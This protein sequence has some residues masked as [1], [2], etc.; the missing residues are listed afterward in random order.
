MLTVVS[1]L[2][3]DIVQRKF[4]DAA[5]QPHAEEHWR[6]FV[7]L[8]RFIQAP[9]ASHAAEFGYPLAVQLPGA[10]LKK[11]CGQASADTDTKLREWLQTRCLFCWACAPF[12]TVSLLVTLFVS[13]YVNVRPDQQKRLDGE[14]RSFLRLS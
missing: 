13:L 10:M 14:A 6:G 12:P 5:V 11:L 2:L 3:S 1:A 4:W 7:D 8:F 9:G